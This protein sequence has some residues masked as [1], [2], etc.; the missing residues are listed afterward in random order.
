MAT[1]STASVHRV[2]EDADHAALVVAEDGAAH[3][4]SAILDVV[5]AVRTGQPLAR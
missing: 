5:A 2:V 4:T 1:L 3:T